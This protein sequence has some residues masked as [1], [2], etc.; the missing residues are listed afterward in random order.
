MLL[1]V[2]SDILEATDFSD[3]VTL[4]PAG[5]SHS[6]NSFGAVCVVR[7]IAER[8]RSYLANRMFHITLHG[9]VSSSPL[10]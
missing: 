5:S 2:F 6:A 7:G 3:C 9:S 4:V 1:N 10:S 8:F